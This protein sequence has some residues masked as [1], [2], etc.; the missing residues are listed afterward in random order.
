MIKADHKRCYYCAIAKPILQFT[1]ATR[2][3]DGRKMICR[4]CVHKR[5]PHKLIEKSRDAAPFFWDKVCVLGIEQCW[6]FTGYLFPNGYGQFSFLGEKHYA[7]RI[8]FQMVRGAIPDGNC[9]CHSC[10]NRKCVNPAHLF[11]GTHADNM[12]DMT[13][14]LRG[15]AQNKTHCPRGHLLAGNNLD[16]SRFKKGH[17]ICLECK[18]VRA[19]RTYHKEKANL[20]SASVITFALS[21][22]GQ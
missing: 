16:Q 13:N 6:E 20:I 12:R 11:A 8:A 15:W 9:V 10:D 21:V 14:K 7:H 18:N 22:L 19:R 17:R 5:Y 3:S 4:S 2:S 1:A